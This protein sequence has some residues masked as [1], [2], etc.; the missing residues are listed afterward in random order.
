MKCEQCDKHEATI[1]FTHIVES[2]KKT[3]RLCRACASKIQG[4]ENEVFTEETQMK[5]APPK[6]PKPEDSP[7]AASCP[8]CGASYDDFKKSGRLSCPECYIAFQPQVD[9]LLHRLH[10]A[11]QHCGKSK[12]SPQDL[13]APGDELETLKTELEAAVAEEAFEQA[14]QL[15]DRI[16]QVESELDDGGADQA[17]SESQPM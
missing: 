8:G 5:E 14:A 16:K 15:R 13:P 3:S 10:G 2:E 6:S 4:A 12:V 1:E 9:R 7:T 11:V 17:T